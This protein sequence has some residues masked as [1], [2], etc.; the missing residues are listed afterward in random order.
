[1]LFSCS[2][3]LAVQSHSN[4]AR[5]F[6]LKLKLVWFFFICLPFCV[7]LVYFQAHGW[8]KELWDTSVCLSLCDLF[9]LTRD[10]ANCCICEPYLTP[11]TAQRVDNNNNESRQRAA[12]FVEHHSLSTICWEIRSESRV[13][14][15]RFGATEVGFGACLSVLVFTRLTEQ[16]G[17]EALLIVSDPYTLRKRNPSFT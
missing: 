5:A 9:P 16:N 2:A 8:W 15:G 10:G 3:H 1:M 13:S 11:Q 17:P 12:A 14:C 7:R 6:I 4:N